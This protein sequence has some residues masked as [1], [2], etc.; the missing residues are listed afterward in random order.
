MRWPSWL[1]LAALTGC[2]EEVIAP[3]ELVPVD[4]VAVQAAASEVLLGDSLK[5][6]A[7]GISADGDTLR[8]RQV[9][10]S[11]SNPAVIEVTPGGR[12]SAITPGTAEISATIEGRTGQTTLT[13]VAISFREISAGANHTCGMTAGGNVW[14]W[15][16]NFS[17]ELG[18][19]QADELSHA[20][21]QA[22]T[23]GHV[24]QQVKAGVA[25]TCGVDIGGQAWCWGANYTGQLGVG[26]LLDQSQ[27]AAVL[28]NLSFS[29]LSTPSDH[30]CGVVSG[31]DVYCWGDN[32]FGQLGD[33]TH[34][35]RTSPVAVTGGLAFSVVESGRYYL[36]CGLETGSAWCW[37]SNYSGQLGNDT[38]YYNTQP[39]PVSAGLTY[40]LLSARGDRSC[41][42]VAG[43]AHCWGS[44][45][46]HHAWK[47]SNVPL[48]EPAAPEGLVSLS[49]SRSHTCGLTAGGTAY[50][51]GDNQYGEL[52][53][54]S[55]GT[56]NVEYPPMPVSGGHTFASIHA[57]DFFTCGLEL[58]GQA[59]CW[60]GNF[61][62]ELGTGSSATYVL[63]PEAV[64]GGLTFT[65]LTATGFTCGLDAAGAAHCWGY[66]PLGFMT[67]PSAV[68][69]GIVFDE[70]FAG[71]AFGCGLSGGAAWCWGNNTFGQLGNGS[72]TDQSAPVAVAG[73]HV[74]E[75]LALGQTFTC[76]LDGAGAAWCWGR[77]YHGSLGDGT[78]TQRTTPVAVSGGHLFAGIAAGNDHTC[79]LLTSGLAVCWGDNLSGQLGNGVTPDSPLP[80]AVEGG[81]VFEQL[82]GNCALTAGGDTWCWPGG[83][84][85]PA[86]ALLPGGL[87]FTTISVNDDHGCGITAAGSMHCWGSNYYG[88][89][90]N[91]SV[92][93]YGR[94][95]FAPVTVTGGL[96]FRQVAVGG[97]HT[98]AL[99]TGDQAYCWGQNFSGQLGV[100]G[101]DQ[102]GGVPFPVKVLGQP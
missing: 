25:S 67:S 92:L 14:C 49:E 78:E 95:Q 88:Q 32:Y 18:I 71:D 53:V 55:T 86:P 76:G 90:G 74:F 54:G 9:T 80:L 2:T 98:C 10:W 28:G 66:T 3:G 15:G 72:T 59:W 17:G 26:S 23:G 34:Q 70:I 69:G 57:G 85:N 41:G 47:S 64:T 38:V 51:W 33:G 6:Q 83:Y 40:A 77:N 16:S 48:A 20:L 101:Y 13:A 89:L 4:R 44:K 60:G 30:T 19:G 97:E 87:K 24:F 43:A 99:T 12:I 36:S 8:G 84:N 61:N 52:G 65:R 102:A 46:F 81:L 50:C 93:N 63:Q 79:G 82:S 27:P 56:Q 5:V 11:S 21:P 37:G 42:L 73:G 29:S 45:S 100:A 7:V 1:I 58:S 39:I 68:P 75:T 22:V 31:G 94:R 91:G 62:G 96:T 35:N